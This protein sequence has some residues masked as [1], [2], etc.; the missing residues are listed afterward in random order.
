MNIC[1][2]KW[3][4]AFLIALAIAVGGCATKPKID[5]NARIGNYTFDDAVREMGPPDKSA[6]LSDGT[7]V[8]E[9]L[10]MRGYSRG[11]YAYFPGSLPYY[12]TDPPSP[13]R[14]LR[15]VFSPEGKLVEWKKYSR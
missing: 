10:T 3:F 7:L 1:K 13:D 4:A 9:W 8:C 5:W 12:W 15:L 2:I 11:H 6:K 14:F